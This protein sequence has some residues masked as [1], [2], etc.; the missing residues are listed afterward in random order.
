MATAA[1]NVAASAAEGDLVQQ[2][3][4][5]QRPTR[6]PWLK[7]LYKG[8][9]AFISL[10]PEAF[11]HNRI[12]NGMNLD[13]DDEAL[14]QF[15]KAFILAKES[16]GDI[17][18][19]NLGPI[20]S[21]FD[22]DMLPFL[23]KYVPDLKPKKQWAAADSVLSLY[24]SAS[25]K[26]MRTWQAQWEENDFVHKPFISESVFCICPSGEIMDIIGGLK[27]ALNDC[28]HAMGD[29]QRF[30]D[31]LTLYSCQNENK[32]GRDDK[33]RACAEY[34]SLFPEGCVSIFGLATSATWWPKKGPD[35]AA[36]MK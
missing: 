1:Q 9:R 10:M 24:N 34:L 15:S 12:V 22:K 36:N 8:L 29:P 13:N 2:G 5:V 11:E 23:D 30:C 17:K 3:I 7:L 19:R 35:N 16:T 33:W 18:Y 28:P 32:F 6:S 20:M 27:K 31:H 21:L 14:V 25:P 4:Q 26:T